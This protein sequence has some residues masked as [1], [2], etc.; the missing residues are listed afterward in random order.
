MCWHD[1][2]TGVAEQH[3]MPVLH[4]HSITCC[5]TAF[6]HMLHT[7]QQSERRPL[8]E[9]R[10]YA[11]DLG[12]AVRSSTLIACPGLQITLVPACMLQGLCM[13]ADKS[14]TRCLMPRLLQQ[15]HWSRSS[16][17]GHWCF[18]AGTACSLHWSRRR[19]PHC[20]FHLLGRPHCSSHLHCSSHPHCRIPLHCGILLHCSCLHSHCYPGCTVPADGEILQH[21]Y[22]AQ[23]P[24]KLNLASSHFSLYSRAAC[25]YKYHSVVDVRAAWVPLCMTGT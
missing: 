2:A 17:T 25:N 1:S 19:H 11:L 18:C 10:A 24:S 9:I 16:H 13:H 8:K 15:K 3:I 5:A 7:C 4:V 23:G 20:S 22:A 12:S 6:M 21:L 14:L